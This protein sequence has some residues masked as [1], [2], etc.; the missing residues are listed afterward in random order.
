MKNL[1]K[2]SNTYNEKSP[3]DWK[4]EYRTESGDSGFCYSTLQVEA[5]K[6]VEYKKGSKSLWFSI[7]DGEWFDSFKF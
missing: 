1:F 6:S 5:L 2:K 4:C 7:N 3:A